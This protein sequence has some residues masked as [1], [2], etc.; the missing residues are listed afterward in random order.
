MHSFWLKRENNNWLAGW[1]QLAE[2]SPKT[3]QLSAW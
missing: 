1:Q 3:E 2:Q